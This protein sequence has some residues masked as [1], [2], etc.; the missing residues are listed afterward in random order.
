MDVP[1][2]EYGAWYYPLMLVL[3]AIDASV[4][5][6]PSELF[7]LGAGPLVAT[8]SL[9]LIPAYLAAFL[10]CWLG[11]LALFYAFRLR[12]TRLLDR[13]TWG[14]WIHRNALRLTRKIGTETTYAGLIGIR[15]LSGGR[16]AAVVAAALGG[17]ARRPF[18][19]FTGVGSALWAAYMMAIGYF[20]GTTTGLPAWASAVIGMVVGTL[21]GVIFAMLLTLVR[22]WRGVRPR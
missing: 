6:T 8:G 19:L 18:I 16:T 12:L 13:F 14:R 21:I 17:V 15:F 20:V 9:L 11:D 5:P 22:R 4:P 1:L 7:V 10:G 2:N 3:V